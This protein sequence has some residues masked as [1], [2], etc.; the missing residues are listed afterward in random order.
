MA[1]ETKWHDVRLLS[2]DLQ[3]VEFSY[4]HVRMTLVLIIPQFSYLPNLQDYTV[5]VSCQDQLSHIGGNF[6]LDFSRIPPKGVT[7]SD[8]S[9]DTFNPHEDAE[10][11]LRDILRHGHGRLAPSLHRLVT[12]LRD[13]LPIVVELETIRTEGRQMGRNLDIFAKAAGWYRLLYGDL[14]YVSSITVVDFRFSLPFCSDRHALDF[15]LMSDQ[16]VAI[17][18]ASHSLFDVQIPDKMTKKEPEIDELVLQPIPQFRDIVSDAARTCLEAGELKMG[19]VAVIDVGAVCDATGV[20]I[21]TRSIHSQV[22]Q[23]LGGQ[24]GTRNPLGVYTAFT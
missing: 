7:G 14:K 8:D 21:L 3:T 10:P 4:A 23:K 24:T 11:F 13:T 2:F 20:G 12:L 6:D 9:A 15:R 17:L 22:L 1:K 18:D 16:R 19:R 5:S